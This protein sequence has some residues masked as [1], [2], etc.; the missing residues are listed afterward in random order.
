MKLV[1]F[2]IGLLIMI[3]TCFFYFFIFLLASVNAQEIDRIDIESHPLNSFSTI[4]VSIGDQNV[5]YY[6]M[7]SSQSGNLKFIEVQDEFLKGE[8]E[9]SGYIFSKEFV[10][11]FRIPNTLANKK[12]KREFV[13]MFSEKNPVKLLDYLMSINEKKRTPENE[14]EMALL[15]KLIKEKEF[16]DDAISTPYFSTGYVELKSPKGNNERYFVKISDFKKE[17]FK[18]NPA[19]TKINLLKAISVYS[20]QN[21]LAGVNFSDIEKGSQTDNFSGQLENLNNSLCGL[22]CPLDFSK[23]L[24]QLALNVGKI[25]SFEV[26][27]N[28]K[29]ENMDDFNKYVL[30]QQWC[31]LKNFSNACFDKD[32]NNELIKMSQNETMNELTKRHKSSGELCRF[33]QV[34]KN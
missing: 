7:D 20:F 27:G 11:S 33:L 10:E 3:Q 29:I 30:A 18:I 14:K 32:L 24:S 19:K 26:V 17:N 5:I 31:V 8:I 21:I 23:D 34:S 28:E 22:E 15:A 25:V 4:K 2:S 1:S 9:L 16:E 13:K 12:S 6:G